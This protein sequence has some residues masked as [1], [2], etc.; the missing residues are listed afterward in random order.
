MGHMLKP[1]CR[2]FQAVANLWKPTA[3][4][5]EGGVPL[6]TKIVLPAASQT[7]QRGERGV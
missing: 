3:L 1:Q 5:L 7:A 6:P 4:H 2:Q